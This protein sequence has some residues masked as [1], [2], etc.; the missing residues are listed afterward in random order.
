MNNSVKGLPLWSVQIYTVR[1]RL[2]LSFKGVVVEMPNLLS[3][4]TVVLLE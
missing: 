4:E 3:E 2:G 1:K